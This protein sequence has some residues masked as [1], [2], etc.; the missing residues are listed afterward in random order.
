[1]ASQFAAV[2]E[3]PPIDMPDRSLS[4][5]NHRIANSLSLIAS[6][7]RLHAAS[8]KKESHALSGAEVQSLLHEIGARIDSVGLLHKILTGK[9]DLAAI[10][11]G[12]YLREICTPLV[13]SLSTVS[14]V[15]LVQNSRP[16]L[17]VAPEQAPLIALV[18]TELVVNAIKYAH[19]TRIR[20]K[21]AIDC[22]QDFDGALVVDVT[23]DG[24][25]LPEGFDPEQ[26]A[27]FGFRILRALVAQLHGRVSFNS[28]ALGLRV[29]LV[30]PDL[31]LKPGAR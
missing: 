24:V 16:G 20:G 22:Q 13:A 9:P 11:I 15:D 18:V 29:R 2:H 21:I 31:I 14:P 3:C 19:P 8:V 1:M 25:G 27:D 4:E 17:A 6:V 26:D 7:V 12:E 5:A 23:D 28:T 30:V 10:D